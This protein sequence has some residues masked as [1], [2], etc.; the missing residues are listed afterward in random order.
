MENNQFKQFKISRG[1]WVFFAKLSLLSP[2]IMTV[3]AI[4]L[5]DYV[6]PIDIFVFVLMYVLSGLGITMGFHRYFVH[7]GFKCKPWLQTVL[8]FLG[9]MAVQGTLLHWCAIHRQH[10]QASDKEGD[11]HSPHVGADHT[12]SSKIRTFWRG[13]MG[14]IF[15]GNPHDFERYIPDL[16]SDPAVVKLSS[17]YPL[18]LL[19]GLLIPG[20]ITGLWTLTFTGFLMGVLWGGFVRV[21]AFQHVTYA[22]NSVCHVFGR[23]S[24]DTSDH[25]KNNWVFGIL[26][27]GEGWHNNH[28][29]FPYSARHGLKWWQVDLSYY[30]IFL[31]E[32][33]GVVWNVKLPRFGYDPTRNA[34]IKK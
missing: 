6:T 12:L 3:L 7:R 23:R 15:E 26:A 9:A 17:H 5:W 10:H 1:M 21:F 28:H 24:Y 2:P 19:M 31:F 32:K 30:V 27:H 4:Y 22:I 34:E 14:W 20:V 29:A 13:H 16:M 11:P 8:G 25:S 33:L 18:A